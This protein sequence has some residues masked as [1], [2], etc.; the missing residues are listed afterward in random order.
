MTHLPEPFHS[1][2]PDLDPARGGAPPAHL[3]AAVLAARA[4]ARDGDLPRAPRS[5]RRRPVLALVAA[6]LAVLAAAG[7]VARLRTPEKPPVVE[8]ATPPVG[9][10]ATPPVVK[11]ATPVPGV[12]PERR[13]LTAGGV[14]QQCPGLVASAIRDYGAG[15][16]SPSPQAVLDGVDRTWALPTF[17]A[18][19]TSKVVE[20][21]TG[22]W[23]VV[24]LDAAGRYLGTASLETTPEGRWVFSTS[25]NCA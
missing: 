10:T 23:T 4:Q 14:P 5:S 9:E 6:C 25:S 20:R 12:V 1:T 22:T 24:Y 13:D 17:G 18:R 8:I 16:G 19:V 2:V 15:A 21:R 11:T 7:V 3:G